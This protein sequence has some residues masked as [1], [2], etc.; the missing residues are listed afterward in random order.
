MQLVIVLLGVS[1]FLFVAL[2]LSGDPVLLLVPPEASA[3]QIESVRTQL[4]LSAPLPV[5]FARFVQGLVRLD[6]GNSFAYRLPAMDVVLQTLPQT[7]ALGGLAIAITLSLAIPIGIY[8]A[9]ARGKFS[10]Q[11]VLFLTF[12]G[13]SMPAFWLGLLLIL[14]FSVHLKLLPS[15]GYGTT[16]HYILPAVTLSSFLLAR[17]AR[18]TRA[19]MIEVLGQDYIRTSRAKGVPPNRIYFKHALRNS[20][21]P[22]VTII[23]LDFG[24]MLGG[25]IVTETIFAWPGIGRELVTAVLQRDYPVV[26]AIAFITALGV[27]LINLLVEVSYGLFDPRVRLDH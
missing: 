14:V 23:G 9:I 20:L 17:L 15:F 10:A 6:F 5:Q 27:V 4:G 8:C 26:Q 24:Y 16:A 11:L 22:I 12:V 25:A 21:I 3:E 7:L 1:A 2:R 18:I 13:Q 19:E